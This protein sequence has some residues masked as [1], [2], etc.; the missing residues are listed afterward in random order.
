MPIRRQAKEAVYAGA[1][2]WGRDDGAA[3]H[4]RRKLKVKP[5]P[6]GAGR[7]VCRDAA[8]VLRLGR[9]AGF[10]I[11][12]VWAA[13]C[14]VPLLWLAAL[15]LQQPVDIASGPYFLP[16]VDFMP[17]ADGWRWLF[18]DAG[19]NAMRPLA[20]SL[21]VTT[22]SALATVALAAPAAYVLVGLSARRQRGLLLW[23]IAPRLLPPAVL[24]GGMYLMAQEVGLLDTR[25]ALIL[26]DSALNLPVAIWLL[27]DSF[28]AI[29]AELRD[30][31]VIDGASQFI[32]FRRIALPLARPGLAVALLVVAALA[33]GEYPIA[34]MLTIDRAQVLPSVLVGMIAVREQ[35]AV[36]EPRNAEIA[37]LVL[38][39][40]APPVAA[41]LALRGPLV[42]CLPGSMGAGTRGDG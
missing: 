28:A 32:L 19:L 8:V 27:R 26:A 7:L 30:A 18:K 29:P 4:R 1:R 13:V 15:S 41:A 39:M 12:T 37:A 5:S 11:L 16:F 21:V 20:T 36:Y 23:L 33:W 35:A 14:I 22:A 38:T 25:T 40:A 2:A 31:A 6:C 24:A 10:A 3:S 17:S 9:V 42:R 34:N